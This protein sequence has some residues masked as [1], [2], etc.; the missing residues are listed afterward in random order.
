MG[1][2][3]TLY[4]KLKS[5]LSKTLDHNVLKNAL[6]KKAVILAGALGAPPPKPGIHKPF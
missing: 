5:F 1:R 4:S 6:L 2:N 3:N